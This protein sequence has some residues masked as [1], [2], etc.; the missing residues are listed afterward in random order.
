MLQAVHCMG[1]GLAGS[2]AVTRP[3]PLPN[4][5]LSSLAPAHAWRPHNLL[6]PCTR[7]QRERQHTVPFASR[8]TEHAQRTMA[9]KHA[10]TH[11][12]T[13]TRAHTQTHTGGAHLHIGAP[14]RLLRQQLLADACQH[15]LQ[16][17]H[18]PSHGAQRHCLRARLQGARRGHFSVIGTDALSGVWAWGNSLA[19]AEIAASAQVGTP[20]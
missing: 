15:D 17:R 1:C 20:P 19:R 18:L 4:H 13:R 10:R 6:L 3:L 2:G 8:L 7:N 5:L 16:L 11:T 9:G 14:H 12:H